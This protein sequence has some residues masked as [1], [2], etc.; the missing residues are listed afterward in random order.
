MKT[1][2]RS[3]DK[4]PI[5][6]LYYSF[7]IA[8]SD[9]E[10]KVK[11][12]YKSFK[13]LLKIRDVNLS[14]SYGLFINEKLNYGYISYFNDHLSILLE[15]KIKLNT[16]QI[17]KIPISFILCGYRKNF[18]I[19]IEEKENKKLVFKNAVYDSGT[20]TIPEFR[21]KGY[22]KIL[23]KYSIEKFKEKKIDG[24]ILE[25]LENNEKAKNLYISA[26]FS[27]SRKFYCYKGLKETIKNT[28]ENK[29]NEFNK[30]IL[31]EQ[32]KEF[33][34]KDLI[35]EISFKNLSLKK[36]NQ[37]YK[38]FKD[39][40]DTISWQNSIQSV[41]NIYNQVK[42]TGLYI[43]DKLAALG[44]I[45]ERIGD[46]KFL[47]IVDDYYKNDKIKFLLQMLLLSKLINDINNKNISFLNIDNNSQLKEFLDKME[48]NNFINQF[49]M[50]LK[51]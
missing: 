38:K 17:K 6:S 37:E 43:N 4:I 44:C 28:I 16:S 27:I 23:L 31:K 2:I 10:I 21:N 12:N 29:V 26:G 8:F 5:K 46:I 36:L 39:L 19:L 41:I 22:S 14:L 15:K 42:I 3:L 9:Y 50:Y 13:T 30:E 47:I 20:A 32:D 33:L 7:L 40:F 1:K 35:N 18:S 49:E 24:F 48:F 25:V 34:F 45:E 11:L 51:F